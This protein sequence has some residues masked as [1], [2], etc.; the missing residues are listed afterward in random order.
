MIVPTGQDYSEILKKFKWSFSSVNSYSNCKY[1]FWLTYLQRPRLPKQENAF[2]QWGSF[3]H[4]I[5]ERFYKGVLDFFDVCMEYEDKYDENV[6]LRFPYN[7]YANLNKKYYQAGLDALER[8]DDLR[9]YL[10]VLDVECKIDTI[11]QDAHFIGY[12]DL[13]LRDTR[14]DDIIIVDHKSKS[15]FTSK[16]EQK[17]Y[18]R[19]L[20]LYAIYVKEKYGKYPTKLVFNMFRAGTLVTIDFD[21]KDL[22]EAIDWFLNSIADIY[23]DLEFLDKITESYEQQ[24]KD[25]ET[26]DK[27]DFFCNEL[28]GVREH[29]PR[30]KHYKEE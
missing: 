25:I 23:M 12:A 28:C 5:Y 29:C 27:R 6:T 10:E 17:K 1:C 11:I 20:Y 16:L 9:S 4:S 2:A 8:F 18:A 19:Q 7:A 22:Q 24:G 26:F 13:I 15:K 3:M 14:T 30:S 21:E